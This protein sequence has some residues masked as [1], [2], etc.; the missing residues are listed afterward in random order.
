[1]SVVY[2]QHLSLIIFGELI[3]FSFHFVSLF[4][5]LSLFKKI[6]HPF[7]IE[8]YKTKLFF[9]SRKVSMKLYI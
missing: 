7:M 6:V 1:M 5:A 4:L 9:P 2:S 3:N 8:V